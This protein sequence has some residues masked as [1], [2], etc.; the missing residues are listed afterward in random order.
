LKHGPR[1]WYK[2]LTNFLLPKGF[3][4]SKVNTTPFTKRFG[5]DLFRCQVYVNNII[6][7][8]KINFIGKNFLKNDG[9]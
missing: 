5:N 1:A 4:T 2:R 8:S 9:S 6:Y 7:G 3:N